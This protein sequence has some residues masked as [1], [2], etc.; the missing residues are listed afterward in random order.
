MNR[1]LKDTVRAMEHIESRG[2]SA[3]ERKLEESYLEWLNDFLTVQGYADFYGMPAD[4]A[5]KMIALGRKIHYRN[6]SLCY[7]C[8]AKGYHVETV[9]EA[10]GTRNQTKVP[11]ACCAGTGKEARR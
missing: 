7:P 9:L 1:L 6:R 2:I 3:M 4:K 10:D 5:E 8:G 11:C